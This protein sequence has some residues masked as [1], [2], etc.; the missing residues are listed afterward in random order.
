MWRRGTECS[1]FFANWS[2]FIYSWFKNKGALDY[3]LQLCWLQCSV[4]E[5]KCRERP[6]FAKPQKNRQ[7]QFKLIDCSWQPLFKNIFL[8]QSFLWLHLHVQS[9]LKSTLL[10]FKVIISLF[11]A[12]RSSCTNSNLFAKNNLELEICILGLS[13]ICTFKARTMCRPVVM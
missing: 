5:I 9:Q 3:C 1:A 2:P 13:P 11:H 7:C 10:Y 8:M 6:A 12:A 4:S